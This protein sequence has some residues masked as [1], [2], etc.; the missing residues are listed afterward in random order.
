MVKIFKPVCLT[1]VLALMMSLGLTLFVAS[2]TGA[3]TGGSDVVEEQAG[4]PALAVTN[5]NVLP[6]Y[7]QPRQEIL[8]TAD[9]TNTGTAWGTQTLDLMINGMREQSAGVGVAPGTSQ[10]I[11]FTVYKVTPGTYQVNIGGATGTLY[12]MQ[13]PPTPAPPTP[14]PAIPTPAPTPTPAR[15]LLEA[16][17]ELDTTGVI[18]IIIIGVIVVGGIVVAILMA[19]K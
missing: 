14:T 11:R 13:P 12:I 5:L 19:R 17:G 7:A 10:P 9:V 1:V 2:P 3:A 4:A 6:V 15:G 18:A 16:G 8:I